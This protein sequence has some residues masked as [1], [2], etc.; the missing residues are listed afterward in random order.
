MRSTPQETHA[1]D[2]KK[3]AT[4]HG[5]ALQEVHRRQIGTMRQQLDAYIEG[6]ISL[7]T[8]ISSLEILLASLGSVSTDWRDQFREEWG[9]LEQVYSVAVVREQAIESAENQALM[10]PALT[11]MKAM[12]DEIQ[13]G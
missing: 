8:L 11:R 12:L 4:H 10:R 9:I 2:A 13:G 3:Q 1:P 5:V 7:S 6:R